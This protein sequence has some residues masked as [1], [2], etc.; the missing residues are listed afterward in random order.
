LNWRSEFGTKNEREFGTKHLPLEDKENKPLS[1]S[2]NSDLNK[3]VHSFIVVFM[4]FSPRKL[5]FTEQEG[6]D[7][8][9][10]LKYKAL[11]V[12]PRIWLLLMFTKN[13]T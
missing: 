2:N 4:I 10:L 7:N 6:F 13:Y 3:L 1:G 11:D 9:D 8:S 5:I 12:S